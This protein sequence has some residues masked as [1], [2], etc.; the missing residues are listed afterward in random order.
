MVTTAVIGCTSTQFE[1]YS[2]IVGIPNTPEQLKIDLE[3]QMLANVALQVCHCLLHMT[4]M[5]IYMMSRL[6][7]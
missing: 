4:S 5:S 6:L 7:A 2:K 3:D 1:L